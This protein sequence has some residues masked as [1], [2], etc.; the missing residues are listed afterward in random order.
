METKMIYISGAISSLPEHKW[1]NNF[2]IV[3]KRLKKC[4]PDSIIINPIR[5]IPHQGKHTWRGYMRTD[6]SQLALCDE[7]YLMGNWWRS[8]GCM[9]EMFIASILGIKIHLVPAGWL[10]V[11]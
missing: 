5:L 6:I 1:K 3:E 10:N 7:L 8:R 11:K 4:L 9:V 2:N